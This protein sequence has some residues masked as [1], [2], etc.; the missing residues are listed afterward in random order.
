MYVT[1]TATLRELVAQLRTA[2]AVAI[3]TEFM[4]ERTYYARLCLIQLATDDI[5]A[6]V[7]PLAVRGPVAAVRPAHR[8]VR[9]E[10]LPR[11]L[12]G[13]RDLLP[14]LRQRDRCPC[15]TRRSP[16]RSPASRSRS[17]TGRSSRSCSAWRSTRATPSPTGRGGRC[18]TRRS[19]T[20]ST[21]CATCP[22]STAARWT[23]S[24]GRGAFSG[25]RPTSRGWRTRR[26]TSRRPRGAVAP[27]QA[28]LVAQP[29]AARGGA[30]GRG[31]ARARGAAPRRAEALG[32]RRRERRRDRPPGA[33]DR[34]GSRRDSRRGRQGRQA[35]AARSD[36]SRRCSAALRVPEDEL[37]SLERSGAGRKATSTV[38]W[39]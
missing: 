24:S 10:D 34:R 30:R 13:P 31:V 33:G 12:P 17:A 3:D 18:R 38:R 20:R 27:R 19:S 6:I 16:P 39:T 35:C 23:S 28:R 5:A 9:R 2:P 1:D 4:R 15:S 8:P 11:R 14:A 7:D 21:T 37:P 22:R 29:P 32:A 36:R 26:P 25:C